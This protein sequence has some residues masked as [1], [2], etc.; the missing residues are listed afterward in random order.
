[1]N[2]I[3]S[4]NPCKKQVTMKNIHDAIQLLNCFYCSDVQSLWDNHITREHLF[5]D[6][7]GCAY[8][9]QCAFRDDLDLQVNLIR[10][11]VCKRKKSSQ[12]NSLSTLR[13]LASVTSAGA[14]PGGLFAVMT[15]PFVPQ[16][17]YSALKPMIKY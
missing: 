9:L 14:Y 1:M 10:L 15:D 8:T 4:L 5:C 11:C 2:V 7:P 13:E 6:E 12:K 16:V 3:K 17:G